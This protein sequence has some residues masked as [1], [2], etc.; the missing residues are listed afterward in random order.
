MEGEENL[1]SNPSLPAAWLGNNSG[2]VPSPGSGASHLGYY[3]YCSITF[4]D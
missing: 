1:V 2:P 3:S 4:Q